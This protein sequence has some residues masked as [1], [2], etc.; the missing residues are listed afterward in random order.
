MTISEFHPEFHP[1]VQYTQR[2]T[3]P[4]GEIARPD[5]V[6]AV[7]IERTTSGLEDRCSIH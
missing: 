7:R 1:A 3:P 2:A 5:L 6:R 4:T